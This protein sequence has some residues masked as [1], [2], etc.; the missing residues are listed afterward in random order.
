[1]EAV[2]QLGSYE[3]L[4]LPSMTS[5]STNY[6]VL[7]HVIP[8]R[9]TFIALLCQYPLLPIATTSQIITSLTHV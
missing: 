5:F 6:C 7:L 3:V 9:E 2:I 8:K 1:M 4:S